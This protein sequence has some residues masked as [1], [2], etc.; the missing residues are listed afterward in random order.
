VIAAQQHASRLVVPASQRS[1]PISYRSH[2]DRAEKALAKLAGPHLPATLKQLKKAIDAT[3][4]EY[5]DRIAA[6]SNPDPD[7]GVEEQDSADS[8]LEDLH[9]SAM[10]E[11]S[12]PDV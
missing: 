4:R 6:L 12:D 8:D 1:R 3:D 2:R 7:A 5:D 10:D 11:D 9:D